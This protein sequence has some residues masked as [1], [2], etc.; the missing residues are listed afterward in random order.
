[1]KHKLIESFLAEK[2]YTEE[3]RTSYQYIINRFL[4]ETC[5][6]HIEELQELD[7]VSFREWLYSHDWGSNTRWLAFSAIRAFLTWKFGNNHPALKLRIKRNNT[8]P[9]R[10]LTLANAQKLYQFLLNTDTDKGKR[11]LAI[12]ALAVDTGLRSSEL[13][14]INIDR[15]DFERRLLTVRVKGGNW[16]LAVFS[17]DTA[18]ILA[19]WLEVRTKY[20]ENVN[21][22]FIG[23]KGKKPGTRI[24]PGGLRNIVR[25]WGVQSGVGKLSPHDFRRSFAAIST[26]EQAPVRLI[27]MAGRWKNI[28][29]VERY[30]RGLQLQEFDPYLPMRRITR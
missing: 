12:Y 6:K 10:T 21:A 18:L 24:T 28:K 13:C 22:V 29:E 5:G 3:T 1:M 23:I 26:L 27:Q 15:I 19:N 2:A 8:G 16:E 30:T 17:P 11:D 4:S 14:S 7:A 9:Q 20:N 25:K